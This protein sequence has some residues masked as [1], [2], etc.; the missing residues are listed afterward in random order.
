MRIDEQYRKARSLY[1][2]N[3]FIFI[4]HK[5]QIRLNAYINKIIRNYGG[6]KTI[7]YT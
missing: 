5:I 2:R 1:K 7:Y 6:S 4:I 3:L